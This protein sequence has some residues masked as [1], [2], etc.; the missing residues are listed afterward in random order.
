[1]AKPKSMKMRTILTLRA[2]YKY[3]DENHRF[4][5]STLNEHLRPYGLEC[6]RYVLGDTAK[7]LRELGVD[8]RQKGQWD[9][10]GFWIQG[11][12]LS[13]AALHRLIFAVSTN[14]H[15]SKSQATD[16]LQSLSPIVTIYQEPLL[17]S[18]VDPEP[19]MEPDDTLYWVY[20]VIQ[21]AIANRRRVRYTVDYMK[22]NKETHTL[23]QKRQWSTLFTPKCIYQ[24][25]SGLYMVGYN[26]SDKRLEVVNLKN[27]ADIKIAFKHKD[28]VA[29][30]TQKALDGL[31]VKALIPGEYDP[32]IYEGP[33]TFRCKGQYVGELQNSFGP[34]SGIVRKDARCRAT[35]AVDCATITAETLSWLER[36]PGLGIRIVGPEK[37]VTT[38]RT[39]YAELSAK[40]LRPNPLK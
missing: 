32:V 6:T 22:Y 1:M 29:D 21:E 7:V 5:T 9:N 39:H 18:N 28:T 30:R 13:E 10:Q 4:H 3:S 15:L 38:I 37:A 8:V 31:N 34:P 16:I 14:P 27:I 35:Y 12:P 23:D 24:A 11:R 36:V 33:I 20:S 25:K 19:D 26:N 40:I 17:R 2:L